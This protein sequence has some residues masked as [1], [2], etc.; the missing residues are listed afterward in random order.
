M[1]KGDVEKEGRDPGP[2]DQTSCVKRTRGTRRTKSRF[3]GSCR[4]FPVGRTRSHTETGAPTYATYVRPTQGDVLPRGSV[5]GTGGQD[6]A[7]T[8][9]RR[10]EVQERGTGREVV[11]VS[12]SQ[13]IKHRDDLRAHLVF[14]ELL[15]SHWVSLHA[16]TA[17]VSSRSAHPCCPYRSPPGFFE[18]TVGSYTVRDDP[19]HGA[20]L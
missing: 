13:R 2:R 10:E 4:G 8:T 9:S 19:S 18:P 3:P 7:S 16:S 5:G 11:T 12:R 6:L 14:H 17:R 20:V 15:R 1:V